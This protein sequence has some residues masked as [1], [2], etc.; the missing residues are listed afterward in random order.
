M[1][2]L[3]NGKNNMNLFNIGTIL[4]WGLIIYNVIKSGSFILPFK[5]DNTW[6]IIS[7]AEEPK[8]ITPASFH[9]STKGYSAQDYY[10]DL[11][12]EDGNDCFTPLG[13]T[14]EE[15]RHGEK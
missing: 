1:F 7:I 2:L 9:A 8:P 15:Y 3:K 4:S 14:H 6:Y 12:E 11:I 13:V 10:R 5:L